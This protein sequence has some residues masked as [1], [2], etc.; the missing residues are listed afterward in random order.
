MVEADVWTETDDN[1]CGECG[2][3]KDVLIDVFFGHPNAESP[4]VKWCSD[5]LGYVISEMGNGAKVVL[6]GE[7]SHETREP[8]EGE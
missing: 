2:Q 6:A 3:E 5:C 7:W 1:V 4:P 8:Q